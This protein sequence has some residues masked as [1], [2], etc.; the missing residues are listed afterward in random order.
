MLILIHIAEK[1]IDSYIII[2]HHYGVIFIC[3]FVF[4]FVC[5]ELEIT[6][7]NTCSVWDAHSSNGLLTYIFT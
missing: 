5:K 3:L 1:Q 4:L 6:E 7:A 2:Y